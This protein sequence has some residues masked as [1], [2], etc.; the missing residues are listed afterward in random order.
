MII[1]ISSGE[2]QPLTEIA[3]LV[4]PIPFPRII[5]N[6][7]FLHRYYRAVTLAKSKVEEEISSLTNRKRIRM[8]GKLDRN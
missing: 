7:L 5:G 3:F 2:F 4:M 6:V 1:R 8:E